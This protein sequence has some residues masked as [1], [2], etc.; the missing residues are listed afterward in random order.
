MKDAHYDVAILGSGIAGGT[1]GLIL[2]RAGVRVL[3][4]EK[5]THPKFAVGESTIPQTSMMFEFMAKRF[6][7][8]ELHHLGSYWTLSE[9]VSSMC[10]IKKGFNYIY[11]SPGKHQNPDHQ[12][13][14]ILNPEIHLYRQDVDAYLAYKAVSAGAKLQQLTEVQGLDF[15]DSGVKIETSRGTFTAQYVVDAS[16]PASPLAK[17]FNLRDTPTRCETFSRSIYTHMIDMKLYHECFPFQTVPSP[18]GDGTLHHIFDGGWIWVI[19]FNNHERSKNPLCSVGLQLDERF[20]KNGMTPEQEFFEY[21]NRLPD[22]A[23]QFK[24]ARPVR[25]WVSVDRLQYSS[26]KTTGNRFC[27]LAHAAGFID[28]LYSRGLANTT[29]TINALAP[30]L[31]NAVRTRDFSEEKFEYVERL[32]RN[33]LDRNDQVVRGSYISWADY[34]FWNAW[35]R[36]WGVA[37][38]LGGLRLKN[39][40]AQY[41]ES[42]DPAFLP[43]S[44][45]PAGFFGG[46]PDGNPKHGAFRDF[47]DQAVAKA[48]EVRKGKLSPEVAIRFIYD[49]LADGGFV[50][51]KFKI[52][53]D[54]RR[55]IKL[56]IP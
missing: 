28:P 49:G 12:N 36:V 27:V 40:L 51:P 4:L 41:R 17:K 34:D 54:E 32:Q 50:D 56:A 26:R 16:G 31:I 43:D 18:L 15:N 3:I 9:H 22:A 14:T 37:V 8:P 55:Y 42:G 23:V 38:M 44:F 52:A 11:H 6:N 19:P 5:D 2:A 20:P 35:F 24:D 30:I 21:L 1:L 47:F 53:N 25:E 39:L 45:S 48:Y 33:Q 29:E 13:Q 10:G 7:A 46:D